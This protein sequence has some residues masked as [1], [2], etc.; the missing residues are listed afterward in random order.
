VSPLY[1]LPRPARSAPEPD[2]FPW[3]EGMAVWAD[4][5]LEQQVIIGLTPSRLILRNGTQYYRK[6]GVRVGDIIPWGRVT[7]RP[8]SPEAE[9]ERADAAERRR[10]AGLIYNATFR[11]EAPLSA[12]REALAVLRQPSPAKPETPQLPA[13]GWLAREIE[14]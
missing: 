2:L 1:S 7:I 8:D 5:W 3:T 6:N 14:P 4:G 13:P 9:Q 11:P 12:L 10:L